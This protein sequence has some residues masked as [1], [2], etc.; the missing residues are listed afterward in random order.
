MRERL[1][2]IGMLLQVMPVASIETGSYERGANSRYA[3]ERP[4]DEV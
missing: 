2:Q 4:V 1:V 3:S